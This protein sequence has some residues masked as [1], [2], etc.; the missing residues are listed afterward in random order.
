MEIDW[1]KPFAENWQARVDQGRAPHAV[2]LAGPP[3]VGKRAAAAWMAGH[4]LGSCNGLAVP[5][6]PFELPAHPDLRWL[7]REKDKQSISIDQ[8]RALVA[9]LSLTSYL[10]R[11]KAAV[12]DPADA[13]NR[14]AANSLLKTLEEPPGD[15]LLILIADR[16]GNLPATVLS[17]CQRITFSAPSAD[18]AH[19]WLDR[20]Q[21]GTAWSEPL[22]IAGN[23]PLSALLAAE[24]LELTA[25]LRRDLGA[26]ARGLAS[27]L[28]VAETWSKLDLPFVLEWLARQIQAL[29]KTA[30]GAG[31][32]GIAGEI[33]HTVLQGIDS[34]NLFCYLDTIN[35]LRNQLAGTFNVQ[36]ALENLLIEWSRGLCGAGLPAAN[37][38]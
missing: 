29:A 2:L 13:L 6:Y 1:L 26:V 24:R 4:K 16:I 22:R 32:V 18:E 37:S 5:A 38:R 10:G 30:L 36:L 23:A 28:A 17:R 12:V 7:Q 21:P 14:N 35:R 11:G 27:P 19:A 25:T 20:L 31:G 8:V 15:A 34:R 3:G 33:D 9:D